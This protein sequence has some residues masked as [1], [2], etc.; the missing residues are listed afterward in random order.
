VPHINGQVLVQTELQREK[1]KGEPRLVVITVEEWQARMKG[2]PG[3]RPTPG[4]Q[5]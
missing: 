3:R 4:P 5:G 2:L 1:N